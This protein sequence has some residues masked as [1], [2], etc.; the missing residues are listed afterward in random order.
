VWTD[1]VIGTPVAP[2]VTGGRRGLMH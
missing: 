1:E 2:E